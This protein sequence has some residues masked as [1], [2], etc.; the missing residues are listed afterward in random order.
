[1]VQI[2]YALGIDIG[3][4][5]IKL[6]IVR[7]DGE[8]I[9][10]C[11]F[12]SEVMNDSMQVFVSH[13]EDS[14]STLI[15]D[16]GYPLVGIGVSMHGLINAELTSPIVC[17]ATPGLTGM[18]I[19]KWLEEKFRLPARLFNDL[20]AHALAQ[21]YYG[22]GRGV[23]RFMCVA[24]GT[25]LGAG[26][27]IDGQPLIF[28]GGTTGDTG[29][30]ILKPG[31]PI[32]SYGVSG[33]AEAM[34]GTPAIERLAFSR[35]GH[36]VS[37][38]NVITAA[39]QGVDLIAA[40]IIGDIGAA[41]GWTIA[42]LCPIFQPQR[43]ALTGGT[44]EAGMVFLDS[45]RHQYEEMMADYNSILS[46]ASNG[47]FGKTEIVLGNARELSGVIGAVTLQLQKGKAE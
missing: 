37:A 7:Q 21:Y 16:N 31:G 9:A 18:N 10:S 35:Y 1:M 29:R 25:G 12:P 33:S 5:N 23:Q 11:R 20:T 28:T 8:V 24:V 32:C 2:R 3:G 27:I 46:E 41:V 39:Q 19:I 4:T 13:L 26:V 42:L 30:L 17:A 44:A 40:E 47:L 15:K 14:V 45:V 43:V 22:V 38:H 34:C 6:G 36:K